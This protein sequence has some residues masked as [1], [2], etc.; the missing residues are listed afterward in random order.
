MLGEKILTF[1]NA[2]MFLGRFGY[3][4]DR[5]N[6]NAEYELV[7]SESEAVDIN[8]EGFNNNFPETRENI[9]RIGLAGF[10]RISELISVSLGYHIYVDGRNVGKSQIISPSF[11]LNL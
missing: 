7:M 3:R 6:V 11:I 1:P 5:W 10:Y 8:G 4:K 9:F 2:V